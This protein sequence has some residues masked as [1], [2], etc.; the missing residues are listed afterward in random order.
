MRWRGQKGYS[1]WDGS[2]YEGKLRSVQSDSLYGFGDVYLGEASYEAGMK[3]EDYWLAN[4][5]R[6]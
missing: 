3:P 2:Y 6:R 5:S 4:G 1:Y